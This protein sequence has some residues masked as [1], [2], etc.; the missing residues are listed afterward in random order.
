MAWHR[1]P[2][3]ARW[4]MSRSPAPRSEAGPAVLPELV[5]YLD[6][7]PEPHILFDRQYRI[8]AANAAYRHAFSP[9]ASVIGRTC[10]EV[11]H[12]IAVPCDQA[13]ESCPLARS[14]ASGQ[15]ER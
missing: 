13:G 14:R 2:E 11:S 3:M 6:S 4:R 12:R 1:V 10:Y 15:R 8:V 5:S 9:R 7:L